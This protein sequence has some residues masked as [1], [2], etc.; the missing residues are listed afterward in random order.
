MDRMPRIKTSC[1][2]C[3]SMFDSNDLADNRPFLIE[4][5]G[6]SGLHSNPSVRASALRVEEEETGA[7]APCHYP[8]SLDLLCFVFMA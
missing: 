6:R 8:H 2:S 4:I 1:K 5:A 3:E 7:S